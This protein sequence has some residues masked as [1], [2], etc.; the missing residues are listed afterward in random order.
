MS[1]VTTWAVFP[2]PVIYLLAADFP[3]GNAAAEST[4]PYVQT[5]P[6]VLREIKTSNP[7]D[8]PSTFYKIAI[9]TSQCHSTLNPILNPQNIK[10]VANHKTLKHQRFRISHDDL[11]N[12]YEIAYDLLGFASKIVTYPD[13]IIVCG[14]PKM[15]IALYRLVFFPVAIT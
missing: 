14:I 5:C 15:L 3:H 9:S 2:N 6:S 1:I 12:I 7:T 13:L 8:C 4:R 11:Y 10:Q